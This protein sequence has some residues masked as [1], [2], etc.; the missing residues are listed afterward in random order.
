MSFSLSLN[1]IVLS[2]AKREAGLH[3]PCGW[4]SGR[5]WDGANSRVVWNFSKHIVELISAA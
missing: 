5:Q 1:V 4:K 2:Q 3:W